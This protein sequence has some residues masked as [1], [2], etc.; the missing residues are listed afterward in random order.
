MLTHTNIVLT[1]KSSFILIN[2]RIKFVTFFFGKVH[3]IVL[4]FLLV[5]F[6]L[7][8][9][10]FLHIHRVFTIIIIHISINLIENF[11]NHS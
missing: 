5:I 7:P 4:V 3:Y 6:E 2:N 11:L 10:K 9:F 1:G 8:F